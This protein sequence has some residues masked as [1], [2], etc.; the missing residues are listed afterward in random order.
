MGEVY[1]AH[2]T[3]L[4]RDIALKLLLTDDGPQDS[5]RDGPTRGARMIHEARAAAALTHPN[6]VSIHDVGEVVEPATLRGTTYIAM[7]LIQGH[8]LRAYVHPAAPLGDLLR[9]LSE[10]ALVLHVA[11]NAGL[12]HR[13]IKP[14]NVMVRDDGVVKVLDFGIAKRSFPNASAD[15]T[16][17]SESLYPSGPGFV[18]GTPQYMAPEQ[19]RN[20]PL[21]GRADQFSW[22]VMAFELL[23]GQLPWVMD[24]DMLGLISQVLSKEPAPPSALN[25]AIPAHVDAVVLRAL[26]KS[27]DQRFSSM[28]D[29]VDV[30]DP[31]AVSAVRRR[32]SAAP[33]PS[34]PIAFAPTVSVEGYATVSTEAEVPAQGGAAARERLA[35]RVKGGRARWAF[36]IAGA[37]VLAAG[38]AIVTHRGKSS[39]PAK[40]SAS[41]SAPAAATAKFPDF[42]SPPSRIPDA[43]AAYQ[44]GM[45][46]LRDANG[47]EALEWLSKATELDPDFAAAH[48]RLSTWGFPLG[49][50][51]YEHAVEAVRR[52]DAL[53]AHDRIVV[54]AIAPLFE[55]PQNVAESL[56]RFT[57]ALAGAPSDADFALYL[58]RT[59]GVATDYS[60]A[61]VHCAQAHDLDPYAAAPLFEIARL[62]LRL[63]DGAAART[64][65][66]A[67]LRVSPLASS[68][69]SL[70]WS[71]D[72]PEGNCRA[73][74]DVA[75]RLVSAHRDSPEGYDKLANSLAASGES[76]ES[77]RIAL[78][79]KLSRISPSAVEGTKLY[80]DAHLA[81]LIG[82][83]AGARKE[84]LQE[85][86]RVAPSRDE[87]VLYPL[88]ADR[89]ALAEEEGKRDEVVSLVSDYFAKRPS[90]TTD[91]TFDYSFY[92][93]SQ[94]YA[95]ATLTRAD[96]LVKR[97]AWL[98]RQP[99]E[100]AI[101]PYLGIWLFAYGIPVVTAADAREAVDALPPQFPTL[102]DTEYRTPEVEW[103][104]G[105]TYRLAGREA[106][107]I[108][109]LT[110]AA[111]SCSPF[112]APFEETWASLDLGLA[113][114]K[115]GD[116]AEACDAYRR[117]LRRW[118]G[119]QTSVTARAARAR[120]RTL[121][122]G[123]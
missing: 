42:G 78:A 68:C 52:R 18:V 26:A 115:I 55:Q 61:Q 95:E 87:V 86:E 38:G 122:C 36:V 28:L 2:D 21:D 83:F 41:E 43:E 35:S 116:A 121:G 24:G 103:P 45:Q 73:A 31:L 113:Q 60:T 99:S 13:D 25:S 71:L 92:F 59:Q 12:V 50:E 104:I 7:E 106:A 112:I 9:W 89:V 79:D 88:I 75:R 100:R 114:E 11:H 98:A 118:G 20:E 32:I 56:R 23:T 58:C 16:S 65:V 96:F 91:T 64:S 22:G 105:R 30:L 27:R 14:E 69:L 77:I 111:K 53:G 3:R 94:L 72:A 48:L 109:F 108:P 54:D 51:S 123:D 44:K 66:D 4:R 6:V 107:A 1:R 17:P 102:S 46:A 117:V 93:T 37:S 49:P 90:W 62:Q 40:A 70:L 97:N 47:D 76:V 101:S 33:S 85:Y 8:S 82:D 74:E 81:V 15:A 67:C 39:S 34:S 19:L 29:L 119:A 57:R 63:D 110:R 84:L 120:S 80:D 5:P 10:V